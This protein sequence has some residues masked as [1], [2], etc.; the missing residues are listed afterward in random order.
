M[1]LSTAIEVFK[2]GWFS[3]NEVIGF[4]QS[5]TGATG[6]AG[7]QHIYTIGIDSGD[8]STLDK[9]FDNYPKQLK[10]YPIYK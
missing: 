7:F 4:V 3:Q 9:E 10:S 8:V 5:T 6:L 1:C 2:T